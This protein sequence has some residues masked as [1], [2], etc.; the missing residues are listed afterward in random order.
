MYECQIYKICNT[1]TSYVYVSSTKQRLCIRFNAHKRNQ[2]T[3]KRGK[4]YDEMRNI[5]FDKFYILP[6][7]KIKVANRYEQIEAEKLWSH[8][9]QKA[10]QKTQ[11]K[12]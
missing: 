6:L 4:I 11:Q 3:G 9:L 2:K 12:T 8:K 7:E 5:G 10:Q 1:E